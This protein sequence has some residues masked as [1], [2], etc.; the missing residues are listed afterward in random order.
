MRFQ[1]NLDP[2]RVPLGSEADPARDVPQASHDGANL[3]RHTVGESGRS[4]GVPVLQ[5]V[6]TA[7]AE[8]SRSSVPAWFCAPLQRGATLVVPAGARLRGN[9]Q[10]EHVWV[11]GEV[12]GRVRAT[13]GTLVVA[14]GA[15]VRG[16][17]HGDGPVVIAGRVEARRGRPAVVARGRLDIASTAR[18]TGKVMHGVVAIYQGAR[19]DGPLVGLPHTEKIG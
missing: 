7:A 2:S 12:D 4:Q 9:C 5:E 6:V 3:R 15:R 17:V 8:S 1:L 13:S 11:L 19:V 18:V 16:G 10:A 14:E